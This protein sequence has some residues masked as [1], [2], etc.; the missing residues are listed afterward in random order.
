M[1]LFQVMKQNVRDPLFKVRLSVFMTIGKL[2]QRF[3]V[4]FQTDAPMI[5]F[6]WESVECIMLNL[7]QRVVKREVLEKQDRLK[8]S[9]TVVKLVE[10]VL[11]SPKEVNIG[12]GATAA[13]QQAKKKSN[14][15][16]ISQCLLDCRSFI[17]AVVQKL[18]QRSPLKHKILRDF[19]CLDPTV[20]CSEGDDKMRLLNGALTSLVECQRLSGDE[21]DQAKDFYLSLCSKEVVRQQLLAYQRSSTRLDHFLCQ[22]IDDHRASTSK[23]FRKFVDIVLCLSH[24]QATVERGF[25]LNK[26]L[27]VENQLERSLIAHRVARDYIQNKCDSNVENCQVDREL[28]IAA[29]NAH[30]RFKTSK[31]K[32]ELQQKEALKLAE[33]KRKKKEALAEKER[34]RKRLRLQLD[35]LDEEI[36][37]LKK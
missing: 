4:E 32:D 26:A 14:P 31:A 35:A 29:R 36:T 5:P 8:Q 19:A 12:F 23:A 21:A 28:I 22:L 33:E 30:N 1:S 20:I 18:Q 13:L 25:S 17:V 6:M 15:T 37:C 16:D 27:L 7:L 34:D 10:E 3:L 2:L 11:V 9:H 24:G